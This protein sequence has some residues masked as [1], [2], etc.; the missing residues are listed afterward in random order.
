MSAEIASL[1]K[2]R[3]AAAS[4][5]SSGGTPTADRVIEYLGGG[6]KTT[7]LRHLKELRDRPAM[8][9]SL[10]PSVIELAKGALSDIY[11]AGV[12][13]GTEHSAAGLMRL[14]AVVAEVDTQID[15]L[16]VE[17]GELRERLAIAEEKLQ[18]EEQ[19]AM[20]LQAALNKAETDL[21]SVASELALERSIGAE[22]LAKLASRIEEGI[23]S[24]SRPQGT[25]RLPRDRTRSG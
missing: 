15:E 14:T 20:D 5:R 6:S 10:P 3:A 19:R 18:A 11:Q 12:R 16:A 13:A 2:V 7:V 23:A 25:I 21:R 1:E 9:D 4:I 8:E 17:N 24:M 22:K